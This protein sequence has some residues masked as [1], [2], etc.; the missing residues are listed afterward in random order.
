MKVMEQ[1]KFDKKSKGIVDAILK[2]KIKYF[3]YFTKSE[4]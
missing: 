3:I 2:N 4:E 1:S